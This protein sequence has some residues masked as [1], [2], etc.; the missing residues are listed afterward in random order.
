MSTVSTSTS[1][2]EHNRAILAWGAQRLVSD[3]TSSAEGGQRQLSDFFGVDEPSFNSFIYA[4]N[5]ASIPA[6]VPGRTLP[7]L[8]RPAQRCVSLYDRASSRPRALARTRRQPATMPASSFAEIAEMDDGGDSRIDEPMLP[9][10]KT[11]GRS[12]SLLTKARRVLS[13]PAMRRRSR[14]LNNSP[15]G[16]DTPP[17]PPSREESASRRERPEHIS[18]GRSHLAAASG[19]SHISH[20]SRRRAAR[21]QSSTPAAAEPPDHPAATAGGPR[22]QPPLPPSGSPS[23]SRNMARPTRPATAPSSTFAE[24]TEPEIRRTPCALPPQKMVRNDSLLGK[25]RRVLST[26]SRRR[27]PFA[28]SPEGSEFDRASPP[29]SRMGQMGQR[30]IT[31]PFPRPRE[32]RELEP[33]SYEPP[34]IS[35]ERS[36]QLSEKVRSLEKKLEAEKRR[37][38]EKEERIA[39][40]EAELKM[41]Q[42]ALPALGSIIET[43]KKHFEA[44]ETALK[45]TIADMQKNFDKTLE[46]QNEAMRL[47]EFNDG[48][49]EFDGDRETPRSS[50]P[51][52]MSTVSE[53]GPESGGPISLRR[54]Q[55]LDT[56]R[57][58]VS[59]RSFF[60]NTDFEI[61][62]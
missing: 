39:E 59:P 7:G 29:P 60:T 57:R 6:Q 10:Q 62:R 55:S 8:A 50:T 23:R 26:P 43:A 38:R 14:R 41:K 30:S 17:T 22:R 33:I 44:K 28:V 53:S 37:T 58:A 12:S 5:N 36:R 21:P 61:S 16:G 3:H 46:Q 2:A 49:N 48:Y 51:G 47:Y 34:S 24:I 40:L 56:H 15:L 54:A 45:G 9:P 32:P 20:S 11:I 42:E 18:G 13:L 19:R 31:S 25:L 52:S 27:S 1:Y 4:Q 35:Y